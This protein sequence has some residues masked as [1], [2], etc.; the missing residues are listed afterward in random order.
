MS[1]DIFTSDALITWALIGAVIAHVVWTMGVVAGRAVTRGRKAT[2]GLRDETGPLLRGIVGRLGAV[3]LVW[4]LLCGTS[5]FDIRD[6]FTRSFVVGFSV[7][8]AVGCVDLPRLRVIPLS[9]SIIYGG[10][11]GALYYVQGFE[12]IL[13]SR[14]LV[15][16]F[17]KLTMQSTAV[18]GT[19]LGVCMT[20][21][22]QM[23]PDHLQGLDLEP[24]ANVSY[25]QVN[26]Y[27][28]FSALYMLVHFVFI[29]VAICGGLLHPLAEALG[30]TLGSTP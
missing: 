20:I 18:I 28:G 14:V 3:A 22:W 25:K 16:E 13:S 1:L 29:F 5:V 12:S 21:L 17:T 7:L 27:R 6:H 19:V 2:D 10:F 11:F 26:A 9:W 23:S 8:V 24:N 15:L 4:L 30:I